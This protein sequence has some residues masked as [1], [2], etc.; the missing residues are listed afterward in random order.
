MH[1]FARFSPTFWS[2]EREVLRVRWL[3]GA[4][5]ALGA[6]G[7]FVVAAL[8]SHDTAAARRLRA[9]MAGPVA[10]WP[11]GAQR[12]VYQVPLPADAVRVTHFEAN[13]WASDSLYVRFTTSSEGLGRFLS[14]L[15][16]GGA[17][18]AGGAT[19]V[20]PSQAAAVGWRLGP[21]RNW[22]GVTLRQSGPVP[23][24]RTT[25]DLGDPLR[26]V[27]YVVATVAFTGAAAPA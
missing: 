15:A 5:L 12:R 13:G 25:V 16:P 10:G 2:G 19:G 1:N 27:V 14:R 3:V 24:R 22:A 8:Q 4:L 7:Y 23:E 11:S 26:P 18:P 20:T 21:G 6:A 17:R 9:E